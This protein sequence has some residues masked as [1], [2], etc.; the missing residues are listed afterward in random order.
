MLCPFKFGRY[1]FEGGEECHKGCAWLMRDAA[2][3]AD[4]CAVS[5]I[6]MY[7]GNT[8]DIKQN[9]FLPKEREDG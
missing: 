1:K 5:V 2:S 4:V 7:C 3:G 8:F 9:T 6:A